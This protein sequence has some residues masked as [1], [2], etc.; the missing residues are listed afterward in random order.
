MAGGDTAEEACVLD[1]LRPIRD[2]T[3][4]GK[5]LVVLRT[6]DLRRFALVDSLRGLEELLARV[7]VDMNVPEQG[8]RP[9]VSE[10]PCGLRIGNGRIEPVKG[11]RR[12]SQIKGSFLQRPFLEGSGTHFCLRIPFQVAASDRGHIFAE[13]DAQDAVAAAGEGHRGLARAAPD[14]EYPSSCR[15]SGER[16]Y[17]VEE[18]V[19]VTRTHLVVERRRSIEGRPEPVPILGHGPAL[20]DV[21]QQ[22]ETDEKNDGVFRECDDGVGEPGLLYRER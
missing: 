13:L 7:A 20:T 3:G 15:Y 1:L 18:I 16:D 14:L 11:G 6:D 10:R 21:P 4:S 8:E 9:S 19:R 5:P 12:N 17:V 2:F 22:A